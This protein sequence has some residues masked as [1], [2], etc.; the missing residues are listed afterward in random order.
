MTVQEPLTR[1]EFYDAI[2]PTLA[3]KEDL[4]HL[5]TRLVREMSIHLR[6]LIGLQIGGLV[7]VAAVLRLLG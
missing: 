7:A 2:L 6:W 4:A 3:T 1:Q 5:E